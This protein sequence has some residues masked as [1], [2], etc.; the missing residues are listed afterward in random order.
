MLII[1][2]FGSFV[3]FWIFAIS[4]VCMQ[5]SW[6]NRIDIVQKHNDATFHFTLIQLVYK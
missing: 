1:D 4:C 2:H 3:Y 5:S 6:C